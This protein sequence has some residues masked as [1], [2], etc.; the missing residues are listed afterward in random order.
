MAI[1][2]LKM[3]NV[4]QKTKFTFICDSVLPDD[5]PSSVRVDISYACCVSIYSMLQS[6]S[7]FAGVF[8][9]HIY[10]VSTNVKVHFTLQKSHPENHHEP[11]TCRLFSKKILRLLY[12]HGAID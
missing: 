5:I 7:Q 1:C 2:F 9:A 4:R 8:A 6:K 3:T 11:S 12:T 10:A